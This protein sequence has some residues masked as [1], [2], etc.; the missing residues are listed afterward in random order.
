MA[1]LAFT[2]ARLG[3]VH[4]MAHPVGGHFNVPHGVANAI[5]LPVVMSYNAPAAAAKY[6]RIAAAMGH[7]GSGNEA[8]DAAAAVTLVRQLSERI[9]I[10]ASLSAVNVPRAGIPALAADAMQSGNIAIN[11]RPTTHEDMVRLYEQCM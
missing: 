3:N 7:R 10:P 11:P 6:A 4:A 2:Q 9:G 1:G 8:Q 5:I